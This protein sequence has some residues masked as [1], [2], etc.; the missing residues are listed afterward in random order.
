MSNADASIGATQIGSTVM[1]FLFGISTLQSYHCIYY[2]PKDS[3]W[4]K[5]LVSLVWLVGAGHAISVTAGTYSLTVTQLGDFSSEDITQIPT[6]F[7]WAIVLSEITA[8][9]V[10]GYFAHRVR[11][12]SKKLYIPVFCWFMSALRFAGCSYIAVG[13][14]RAQDL[15]E[16]L[17]SNDWILVPILIG[18]AC[19]DIII[20]ASMCYYLKRQKAF[21]F[22]RT[23]K[24]LDKLMV[25][26]IE[27]GLLTGTYGVTIYICYKFMPTPDSFFAVFMSFPEV[28][29]I[30]MLVSLN[31]RRVHSDECEAVICLPQANATDRTS[32]L[33][34]RH[35]SKGFS[36]GMNSGYLRSAKSISVGPRLDPLRGHRDIVIEV[37]QETQEHRDKSLDAR[38]PCIA[39]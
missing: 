3:L 4:L 18:G 7:T 5:S 37:T 13:T 2:Y 22:T 27:T 33:L 30:T 14:S 28:F 15:S 23:A 32:S 26:S 6:G 24:M 29:A 19:L 20:A 38:G 21:A 39:T 35:F 16:F 11:V 31:L 34:S 36:A 17:Q 12:F 10:Q 9:L 1:T 25:Y 8:S